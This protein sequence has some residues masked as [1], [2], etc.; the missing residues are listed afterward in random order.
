MYILKRGT[1][2]DCVLLRTIQAYGK[3]IDSLALN[4]NASILATVCCSGDKVK[5][6]EP[7]TGLF[8][9]GYVC[10]CMDA[11]LFALHAASPLTSLY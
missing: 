3:E 10:L 8:V 7:N 2:G 6:W 1:D 11:C 9:Y 5:L 4:N